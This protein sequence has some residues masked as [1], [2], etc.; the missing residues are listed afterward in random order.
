MS[1]RGDLRD[2]LHKEMLESGR[3]WPSGEIARRSLKLTSV[4][5]ATDGL[6]AA[7]LSGDA[8][9]RR[10]IEGWEA[11][12]QHPE[13][14][15]G[16]L[17][18]LLV[19]CPVAPSRPAAPGLFAVPWSPGSP[20][21][22]EVLCVSPAGEG[23]AALASIL[24]DRVIATFTPGPAR[25]AFH[26]FEYQHAMPA[27]Q[28]RILDLQQATRE[29]ALDVARPRQQEFPAPVEDRL[30]AAGSC[31]GQLLE[32]AHDMSF[33]E[34]IDRLESA[35]DAAAPVSFDA[36][37]F[38][39]AALQTIPERPGIYR[40]LDEQGR[41]LYIGKSRNLR[42]RVQSYFR[43]LGKDH[44]RRARLLAAI[45][46]LVWEPTPSEL[47]A[48]ILEG[49]GIRSLHPPFNQQ[50]EVHAGSEDVAPADRDVAFVLCEGD[51]EE[52]SVFFLR[53][54]RA[55]GR[56]RLPRREDDAARVF[57]RSIAEAWLRETP[58]DWTPIA[59]AESILVRR[60]LRLFGD[61]VDRVTALDAG[62]A[63]EAAES[64]LRLATRDRPGWD[65]WRLRS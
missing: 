1:G 28:D 40:F 14:S 38:G 52:V 59:D 18:F 35:Q 32:V 45:H 36:Y 25:A 60:Y 4:T 65:P 5:S 11:V 7:V 26:R 31:L 50:I 54:G 57:A 27:V 33:R 12:R 13:P 51:E 17:E 22:E 8:R 39:P 16:T 53:G 23:L 56:V 62:S 15:F 29:F 19:E 2:A 34:L 55:L 43:P 63:E 61:R 37:R 24:E 64:L 47:E 49:E 21:S 46:D 20:V 6:V 44:E 42:Q 10:T 48:L 9:F 30:A 41:V 58:A 3:A